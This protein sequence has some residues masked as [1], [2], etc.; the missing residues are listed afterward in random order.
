M[1]FRKGTTAASWLLFS[2][3]F[4]ILLGGHRLL[5]GCDLDECVEIAGIRAFVE[6]SRLDDWTLRILF[7]EV[8]IVFR[9]SLRRCHQMAVVVAVVESSRDYNNMQILC[10]TCLLCGL[11]VGLTSSQFCT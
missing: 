1:E 7:L 9:A 6:P 5:D 2:A 3:F 10:T 11:S 8:A 4:F